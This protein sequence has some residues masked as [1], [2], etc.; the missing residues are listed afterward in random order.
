MEFP[1]WVQVKVKILQSGQKRRV[2]SCLIASLTAHAHG[3][4][5]SLSRSSWLVQPSTEQSY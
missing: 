3:K 1:D 4:V 5:H 2:L